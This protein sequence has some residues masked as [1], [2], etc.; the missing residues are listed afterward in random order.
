MLAKAWL[1]ER[2]T[3]EAIF[4]L[5]DALWG[6]LS[7]LVSI[8]GGC[9]YVESWAAI[10]IGFISGLLYLAGS[11]LMIRWGVDDAVDA[12][13]IH[14]I[15]GIWGGIAV[16]LFSVPKYIEMSH[17]EATS[18]GAFYSDGKLLACQL[19]GI[20]F[21]VGWVSVLMIPF[22][23]ILHYVGWLRADSLEEIVGLDI[24][25]HGGMHG[26]DLTST[27]SSTEENTAKYYERR[28]QQRLKQRNKIRRR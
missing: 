21:V 9:A 1:T 4:S 17:P 5:G 26:T 13:P 3:G 18:A 24:S 7:G 25:Y 16:G 15:S 8:T 11:N 27:G 22:F 6:C 28:E 20:L 14:L 10:I 23:C 12:I 19:I 2:R